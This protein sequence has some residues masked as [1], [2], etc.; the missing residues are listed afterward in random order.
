MARRNEGSKGE[1]KGNSQ[2]RYSASDGV[3][4][5]LKLI[6]RVSQCADLAVVGRQDKKPVEAAAAQDGDQFLDLGVAAT[7]R[8][9]CAVEQAV[10]HVELIDGAA[11]LGPI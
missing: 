1:A 4:Q 7:E 5:V 9:R 3:Q 10:L 2:N 11:G 8:F 6:D